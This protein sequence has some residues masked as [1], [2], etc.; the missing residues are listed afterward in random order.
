ML[1][2]LS[3]PSSSYSLSGIRPDWEGRMGTSPKRGA[4]KMERFSAVCVYVRV[5]RE[6]ERE[7]KRREGIRVRDEI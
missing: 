2:H 6:R 4:Y 3:S 7:S 1:L 5:W